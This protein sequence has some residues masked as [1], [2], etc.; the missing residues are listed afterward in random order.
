MS[1]LDRFLGRL[2]GVP[3]TTA[4]PASPPI[5]SKPLRLPSYAME[6]ERPLVML[7][8]NDPWTIRDSFE[9]TQVFGEPGSGKTTGSGAALAKAMLRAGYGGLVLTAKPNECAL[10]ER[11]A[12]ETGREDSL[13]IVHPRHH[14]RFNFLDYEFS[15]PGEGAGFADNVVELFMNVIG[16]LESD[17]AQANDKFW[18]NNARRLLRHTLELIVASGDT[19]TMIRI[20]DVIDSAPSENP[21]THQMMHRPESY[22]DACLARAEQRNAPQ[23]EPLKR[24]WLK[25]WAKQPPK[26]KAGIEATLTGMADPFLYGM[27]SELFCTTSNFTP[28]WSQLGA[29]IV[30]DLSEAEWF[31]AGRRA[32]LLFKYIWQ[33]AVMRRS[34]LPSGHRPVF[35]FMDEAQT[36]TT[37]LDAQFQAMAR[38]S[39]AASVYLTQN[40]SNYLAI[41][42]SHRGQAQTD[43]LLANLGTKIFHRN[44]DHRTNQWASDTIG[45]GM[46]IRHSGGES[47]SLSLSEQTSRGRGKNTDPS[48]GVLF[49]GA[50]SYSDQHNVSEGHN[51]SRSENTGW[52]EEIDYLIQPQIF[53]ALSGGGPHNRF[54][55][56]AIVLKAGKR[57]AHTNLPVTGAAFMQDRG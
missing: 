15:R 36:F 1:V 25:Q 56:Q 22:C 48:G 38:S 16:A 19:P 57:F 34:G 12:R 45:K 3:T 21:D 17:G 39:C 50:S 6:F 8:P 24:Y 31:Q 26:T 51:Y 52:R 13:L 32:Q 4:S 7:T 44:S 5:V 30:I 11:Y 53:T 9:G 27:A 10:W 54:S 41:M 2:S 47:R 40:I 46:L 42:E 14:W 29:V 55:V 35:L 33:R 28:E 20:M 23:L 49:W 18:D 43:S 37:P